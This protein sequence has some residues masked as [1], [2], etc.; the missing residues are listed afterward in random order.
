MI[1]LFYN[2]NGEESQNKSKQKKRKETETRIKVST[3]LNFIFRLMGT[4]AI[5]IFGRHSINFLSFARLY[6]QTEFDRPRVLRKTDFLVLVQACTSF[7]VNENL[8]IF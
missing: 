3:T 7:V 4:S 5:C 1:E 2:G 8:N 6:R